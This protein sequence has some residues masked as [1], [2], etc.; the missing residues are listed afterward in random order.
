MNNICPECKRNKAHNVGDVLKGLC[1]KWYAIRDP[2]AEE[3]CKQVASHQ[4]NAVDPNKSDT[5]QASLRERKYFG[6]Y[7]KALS[8]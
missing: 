6:R 8:K 5:C 3:D 1:P 2:D 7:W 4:V